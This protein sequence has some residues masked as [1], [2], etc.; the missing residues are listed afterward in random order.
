MKITEDDLAIESAACLVVGAILLT[1]LKVLNWITL[2][3]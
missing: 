3:P 1:I 2:L